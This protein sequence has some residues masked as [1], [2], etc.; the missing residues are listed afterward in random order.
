M[1]SCLCRYRFAW[2]ALPAP[3]ALI[4]PSPV[5]GVHPPLKKG[6]LAIGSSFVLLTC[7]FGQDTC[8]SIQVSGTWRTYMTHPPAGYDPGTSYPMVLGFHGGQQAAT[9]A[10]G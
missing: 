3:L 5:S 6:G 8:D 1:R 9:R 7:A 4:K 10:H 2:R